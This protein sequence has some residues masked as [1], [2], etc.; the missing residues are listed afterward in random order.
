MLENF[1]GRE[2]LSEPHG[3]ESFASSNSPLGGLLGNF[4]IILSHPIAKGV[5]RYL[6]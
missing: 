6:Q 5:P 3:L 4:Q 2:E 1:K